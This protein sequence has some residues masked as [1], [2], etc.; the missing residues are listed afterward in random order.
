MSTTETDLISEIEDHL[1]FHPLG[2]TEEELVEEFDTF[3]QEEVS[4]A[5]SRLEDRGTV[6]ETGGR[7]RW[8]G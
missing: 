6:L 8:T 2:S 5:L 1:E 3:D 7:Y 4:D